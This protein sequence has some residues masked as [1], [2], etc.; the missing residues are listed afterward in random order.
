MIRVLPALF[1]LLALATVYVHGFGGT[2]NP[3]T[4]TIFQN[5]GTFNVT[6]N[7][8]AVSTGDWLLRAE[9]AETTSTDELWIADFDYITPDK[10]SCL[11]STS[12]PCTLTT[13]ST[14]SGSY[15]GY[16]FSQF[17][18][19]AT[20]WPTRSGTDGNDLY[21]SYFKGTSGANTLDVAEFSGSL[22]TLL[23][24][25]KT[26]NVSVW[27]HYT[28]GSQ[29][30][31]NTTMFITNVRPRDIN[32]QT[33]QIGEAGTMFPLTIRVDNKYIGVFYGD[34]VQR[35]G[36]R[37]D[38]ALFIYSGD[39]SQLKLWVGFTTTTYYRN[40]DSLAAIMP[41]A[42]SFDVFSQP[43]NFNL[44]RTNTFDYSSGNV[45]SMVANGYPGSQNLAKCTLVAGTSYTACDQQWIVEY[46]VQTAAASMTPLQA[47]MNFNFDIYSCPSGA[48]SAISLADQVG[49]GFETIFQ[50]D[51]VTDV[52]MS[53]SMSLFSVTRGQAATSSVRF[54]EN[55]KMIAQVLGSGRSKFQLEVDSIR[56]CYEPSADALGLVT[57][58][59]N[60][61]RPLDTNNLIGCYKTAVN[62][63]YYSVILPGS[64]D[65]VTVPDTGFGTVLREDR[66]V[67][68]GRNVSF[69]NNALAFRQGDWYFTAVV[70]LTDLSAPQ[71]LSKRRVL[72]LPLNVV[73]QT[74]PPLGGLTN[75][76]AAQGSVLRVQS[77]GCPTGMT[78]DTQYQTCVC[79]NGGEY[80]FQQDVCLLTDATSTPE[81]SYHKTPAFVS[82]PSGIS[83]IIVVSVLSALLIVTVIVAL[84]NPGLF[85]YLACRRHSGYQ[86]LSRR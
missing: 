6:F 44:T 19:D 42:A 58:F 63:T 16:T 24:C 56:V 84:V 20:G 57:D 69:T 27:N 14:L 80:N 30:Y 79:N 43:A 67:T 70:N 39:V 35:V 38:S 86:P 66:S 28:V 25:H 81:T 17:F 54:D 41:T 78:F 62:N 60:G 29:S 45:S 82:N 72:T 2:V 76:S 12:T 37:F 40:T 21:N 10:L 85:S 3:S 49:V 53:I 68:Y 48:C 52:S 9:M 5:V 71:S 73:Q 15:G 13:C 50:P 36:V 75:P 77:L 18:A 59:N 7:A 23:A 65:T 47:T 32:D 46:S 34:G 83:A 74:L 51:L 55:L 26:N 22:D 31:I 11:Y 1:A 61:L 64:L 33:K 8:P 4:D